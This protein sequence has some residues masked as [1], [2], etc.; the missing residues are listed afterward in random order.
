[1]LK[2]FWDLLRGKNEKSRASISYTI[3]GRKYEKI[4]S[5]G[6]VVKDTLTDAPPQVKEDIKE[7]ESLLKDVFK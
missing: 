5:E 6:V 3:N 7:F 2:R 4:T 1:M